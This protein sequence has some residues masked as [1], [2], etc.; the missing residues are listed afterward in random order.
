MIAFPFSYS[1]I[2]MNI[3]L[4]LIENEMFSDL[5]CKCKWQLSGHFVVVIYFKPYIKINYLPHHV[6][7]CLTV[8]IS[9]VLILLL[10]PQP[11]PAKQIDR[12][13]CGLYLNVRTLLKLT[14]FNKLY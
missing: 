10:Q 4:L 14:M 8:D 5:V 11:Q 12:Q 9:F 13:S 2:N 3:K 1:Q 7:V 6:V